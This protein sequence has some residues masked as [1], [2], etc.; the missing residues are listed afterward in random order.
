[1]SRGV[2][3]RLVP[4]LPTGMH[5]YASDTASWRNNILYNPYRLPSRMV[6]R[7]GWAAH[8]ARLTP[9]RV[10][11]L[12]DLGLAGDDGGLDEM[13]VSDE[14][15]RQRT[16][17]VLSRPRLLVKCAPSASLANE[18]EMLGRLDRLRTLGLGVPELMGQRRVGDRLAL[19]ITVLGNGSHRAGDRIGEEEVLR[20][21]LLLARA[22]LTH[23]D[24]TPW[25]VIRV[26]RGLGLCDWE[27]AAVGLRPGLD[28]AH[29]V[30]QMAVFRHGWSAE[31]CVQRLVGE[32]G[33]GRRYCHDLG[34]PF[35]PYLETVRAYLEDPGFLWSAHAPSL[36]LRRQVAA[37]LADAS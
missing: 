11:D 5:L 8:R 1:V 13:V 6:H 20:V 33:P 22:D 27:L 16:R 7:L 24:L 26:G 29:A 36:E 2:W 32:G 4:A 34:L 18:A 25:N 37:A 9:H 12:A 14:P 10:F 30:L 23:G 21:A 31:R 35:E 17:T 3:L 19:T 28:L 15:S